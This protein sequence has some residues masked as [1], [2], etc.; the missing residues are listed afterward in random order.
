MLV[1]WNGLGFD[2]DILAEE[3][4][5]YDECKALA[6]NHVDMMFHILC[7]RGFPVSLDNACHGLGLDGKPSDIS[8]FN[9]PAL[10]ASGQHTSVLKYVANDCFLTLQV[11]TTCTAK[12]CFQ[13]ITKRG[14][15]SKFDLKHGWLP[16]SRAVDI[17]LPDTSWMENPLPR[18]RPLQ[19]TVA[20]TSQVK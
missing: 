10:W 6:L 17:P 5:M 20:R 7:D 4:G 1:T 12:R 14:K 15:L 9:A 2:F 3:S 18:T 8:G 11:A 13:W 16:V 19:W